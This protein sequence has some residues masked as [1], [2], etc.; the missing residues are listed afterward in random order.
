VGAGGAV[1]AAVV[2]EAADRG[3]S[4]SFKGVRGLGAL[5]LAGFAN[6]RRDHTA[7]SVLD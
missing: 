1:G 2:A 7:V 4:Q 3:G 5:P 6:G